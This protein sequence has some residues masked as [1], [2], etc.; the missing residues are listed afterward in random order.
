MAQGN[1]GLIVWPSYHRTFDKQIVKFTTDQMAELVERVTNDT[2]AMIQ[3]DFQPTGK[4]TAKLG[5]ALEGK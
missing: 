4:V 3:Q 1:Q 2:V 5:R